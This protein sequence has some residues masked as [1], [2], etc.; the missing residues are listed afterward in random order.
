MA[1]NEQRLGCAGKERTAP[2]LF[3]TALWPMGTGLPWDFRIGPG[4]ASER[5]HREDMRADLPPRALVVA[6]AGFSGYDRYRRMVA[7]RRSFLL[8]VGRNVHF[9]RRLG[10][11]RREGASVVYLGPKKHEHEPLK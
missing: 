7:A 10:V 1:A 9:L 11:V 6:D 5:R 4:T 2:P 8:R 3:L